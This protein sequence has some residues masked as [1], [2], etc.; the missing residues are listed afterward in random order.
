MRGRGGA[1]VRLDPTRGGSRGDCSP[2]SLQGRGVFIF[3]RFRQEGRA[4]ERLMT[5][6]DRRTRSGR[7]STRP[8]LD[9]IAAMAEANPDA[10]TVPIFREVM[11][12]FETPVSAYLKVRGAGPSFLLESIEG[13]ERLARYSF[14]GGGPYALLS[15][16]D[17]LARLERSDE[18]PALS[19]YSDPLD[20][21]AVLLAERRSP[22]VLDSPLPR[23]TGGAVGYLSYEA[24]RDFEPRVPSAPGAGLE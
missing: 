18:E 4:M 24:V 12:D 23:F 21:L 16:R 19:S 3:G 20:P 2:P 8:S 22:A 5:K 6:S 1:S 13:G 15:L 9:E 7:W 14:M 17:G 11:A 10:R